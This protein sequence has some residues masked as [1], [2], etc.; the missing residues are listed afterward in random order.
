MD[1]DSYPM[2]VGDWMITLLILAIPIVNIIMYL[3]WAFGSSGN[4][5]RKTYCQAG[6]LWG[7]IVIGGMLAFAALAPLIGDFTSISQK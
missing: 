5:S 1:E 3:I 7:V 6:L 2:T 4:M